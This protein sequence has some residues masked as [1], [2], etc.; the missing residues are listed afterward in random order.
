LG[1]EQAA[2]IGMT[3]VRVAQKENRQQQEQQQNQA[4]MSYTF[5]PIAVKLR[6]MGHP[7]FVGWLKE[8][9]QGNSGGDGKVRETGF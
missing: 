3:F 2:A 1:N 6:W 7:Y 4:R 5:P 8:N 9:R